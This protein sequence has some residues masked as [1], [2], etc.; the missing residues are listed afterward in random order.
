MK[1]CCKSVDIF[2]NDFIEKATY[3]ALDEKWRRS[4]VARYFADFTN[5]WSASGIKR[6]LCVPDQRKWIYGLI[7]TSA[8]TL[9]CEIRERNIKIMPIK[10]SLRKDG[11]SGK[12]REIGVESVK[13][14][15]LDEVTNLGCEELWKKKIGYH[16]YASIAGKG[17]TNGKKAI[18]KQIRKK[19]LISRYAWQGDI[20]HCYQSVVVRKLK[21]MLKR[22]VANEVLLFLLFFLIDTYKEGLNI[23]SGLSQYLCNYYLAAAYHYILSL[24]KIRKHKDGSTSSRKLIYFALFYMDD[25]LI[26]GSREADVKRAATLLIKYLKDERGLEVKPDA[27]LF[28]IDYFEN[29]EKDYKTYL[30]RD[31]AERR[32]KPIDMMGYVVYRDHTV[33]R[34]GTFLRARRAYAKAWRFMH[35]GLDIPLNTARKC[36][37]YYGWFKNSDSKYV[38]HKYHIEELH[39]RS[40]EVISKHARSSIYGEAT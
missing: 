1:R 6:M 13:Q 5:V 20:R 35:A 24:H 25:I 18:E 23:G 37:S 17:Q 4:D 33:I 28:R 9:R 26:I 30:E 32:G 36:V 7:Q 16:Q 27:E 3:S 34:S 38:M 8:E 12:L 10:Y 19:Y 22:D 21:R 31:K 29:S 39:N 15:I 2:S 14:L 11:P 40:K